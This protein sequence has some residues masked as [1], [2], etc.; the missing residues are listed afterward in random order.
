MAALEEVESNIDV[1]EESFIFSRLV[2]SPILP[3]FSDECHESAGIACGVVAYDEH[4]SGTECEDTLIVKD[5]KS[6]SYA[7]RVASG[8][9]AYQ[10][11]RNLLA[12]REIMLNQAIPAVDRRSR[13]PFPKLL[14]YGDVFMKELRC[15]TV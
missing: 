12:T 7:I 10:R 2:T 3:P 15:N 6:T 5:R 4:K 1:S 11:M 8:S 14:R 13:S 9:D